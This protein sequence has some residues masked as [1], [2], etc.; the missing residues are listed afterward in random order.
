MHTFST[1]LAAQ[2]LTTLP[3]FQVMPPV[4]VGSLFQPK[5]APCIE[6][7]EYNKGEGE[8]EG[9][10][11]TI[12]RVFLMTCRGT[13]HTQ[14]IHTTLL[15]IYVNQAPMCRYPEY[16]I[17]AMN[18]RCSISLK[19]GMSVVHTYLHCMVWTC[20]LICRRT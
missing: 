8:N 5:H 9:S 11:I 16:H 18:Y 15:P 10:S 19:Y 17:L 12:D 6:K 2:L 14:Y 1:A 20:G 4:T 3:W 13:I 7:R